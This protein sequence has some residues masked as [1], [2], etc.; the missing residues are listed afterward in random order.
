MDILFIIKFISALLYPVGFIALMLFGACLFRLIKRPLFS[1]A[2]LVISLIVFVLSSNLRV[3]SALA[4]TLESRYPQQPSTGIQRH[5]ALVVLGGGIRMPTPPAKQVQLGRASD[6]YWYAVQLYN[7]GKVDKI[8]VSGGNILPQEGLKSEAFYVHQ[9]LVGWGV[10]R[11]D[12]YIEGRSRTTFENK[13]YVESILKQQ[14]VESFLLV[15]S[16]IHM[17]RAYSLFRGMN[18]TITPASADVIVRNNVKTISAVDW[19]PSS[20]AINL[21]TQALHEYYGLFYNWLFGN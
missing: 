18:Y 11:E 8:I 7:A 3:A 15:T 1:Q 19:L 2:C 5:D 16:A 17:P 10:P 20:H 13:K 4:L 21:T 9:L 14:E 6:R 12:V